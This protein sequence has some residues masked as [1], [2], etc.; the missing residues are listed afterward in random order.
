MAPTKSGEEIEEGVIDWANNGTIIVEEFTN[1]FAKMPLF[2]RVMDCEEVTIFKK[3]S[4]KNMQV[5]TTMLA[6]CNP[7]ADFFL[8]EVN[9]KPVS[10]RNQIAFKEG[11]ISRYWIENSSSDN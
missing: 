3:G 5:N 11:I 4:Q 7:D 8:E 6:A 10:F 1:A 2:R 9:G